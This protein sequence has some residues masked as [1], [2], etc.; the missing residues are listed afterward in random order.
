MFN[1]FEIFGFK[2]R[3]FMMPV[4]VWGADPAYSYSRCCGTRQGGVIG[5]GPGKPQACGAAER[6]RQGSRSPR[7]T[8]GLTRWRGKTSAVL[9]L[10]PGS[11]GFP[12]RRRRP[13]APERSEGAKGLRSPRRETPKVAPG[14]CPV[15]CAAMSG[16]AE[17]DKGRSVARAC[18]LAELPGIKKFLPISTRSHNSPDFF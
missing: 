3:F 2:E 15:L 18:R 10:A 13:A 12:S 16:A 6:D 11:T 14:T 1:L 17:Q 8:A 7:Q 9:A 4:H 5:V